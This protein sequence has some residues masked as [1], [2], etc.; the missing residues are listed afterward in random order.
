MQE[1]KVMPNE[2]KLVA[3]VEGEEEEVADE[4]PGDLELEDS[5]LGGLE[6]EKQDD[7]NGRDSGVSS[8][9]KKKRKSRKM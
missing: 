2:D 9:R 4:D 3:E 5:E 8:M 1:G 7:E 6:V